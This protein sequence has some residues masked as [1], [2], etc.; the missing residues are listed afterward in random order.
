[1]SEFKGQ[2]QNKEK[3]VVSK[4]KLVSWNPNVI[5][6]SFLDKGC[7]KWKNGSLKSVGYAGVQWGMKIC[8]FH[9]HCSGGRLGELPS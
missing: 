4:D 3:C 9:G 1:M 7:D 8:E 2:T 6:F 5:L